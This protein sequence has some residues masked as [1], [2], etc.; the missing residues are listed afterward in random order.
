VH[1]VV[2]GLPEN[3]QYGDCVA[4]AATDISNARE[5]KASLQQEQLLLR[6]LLDNV[7][8]SIYFK[9]L[10]SRF[11]RVSA[12]QAQKKGV[13]HTEDIIGKTDFDFFAAEHAQKA[14][15]DEQQIIRTGE[16]VVDIEERE[17]WPDGRVTWVS[18]SKLPLRDPRGRTIGTF[19]ISRD[20]TSRKDAEQ[21]LQI[22]QKELLEASRLAGMAEI[23]SGVLHNIG[24]ALN[25][26]N[27]S[28][29]V[30]ADQLARSR[31]GNFA[32]AAQLLDQHSGDLATFITA[33]ER[34]RQIPSYLLQLSTVLSQERET[35]QREIDQLRK[36]VEHMVEIVAMQQGYARNSCLVE[37][38][39]PSDLVDEAI[40]ISSISLGR[41]GVSV[42]RDFAP[43]PMVRVTRHKVLQILVNLIRNAKYATDETGRTDNKIMTVSVSP[44]AADRVKICVTDNGV[45]IASENLTKIFG[46]GFTT[47]K[48]GHGFGLHS[49]ANAA[50]ELGGSLHGASEGLGHGATFTLELPVAPAEALPAGQIAKSHAA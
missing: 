24:N 5:M 49:S 36:S 43:T 41:H 11:I 9:D 34:G 32:K 30:V 46:F 42:T 23:A 31:L 40:H 1:L 38:I 19:G 7:P 17:T 8:D 45:G 22:A 16:P 28:I 13:G 35:V 44:A 18:T 10:A 48:E 3:G 14:F 15:S 27:T 6:A 47:R 21:K 29:S 33:D 50:K 12:S 4:V 26:V 37:D 39:A 20:I 2:L 25:S